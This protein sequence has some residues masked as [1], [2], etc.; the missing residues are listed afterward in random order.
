MPIYSQV[1][2]HSLTGD[3]AAL[4]VICVVVV[5][6]DHGGGVRDERVRLPPAAP[7][8][9]TQRPHLQREIPATSAS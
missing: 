2:S 4:A 3:L 8:P 5:E 6:A 7:E 9:A 1:S